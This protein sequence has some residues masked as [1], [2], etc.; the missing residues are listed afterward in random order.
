MNDSHCHLNDE[1]LLPAYSS[2]IEEAKEAGVNKI[3]CVGWDLE[4]SLTAI[5][6]AN[7]KPNVF[8]AIGFH[9]E[10]L[11]GISNEKL[12]QIKEL[13][14]SKKVVA[15]GEIGLDFHWFSEKDERAKQEE[16]FI[17]QIDLANALN[18]PVSIHARDAAEATFNVIESHPIK[19]GASLHCYSGSTEMMERFL[20]LGQKIY[21]GFDGPVTYKNS[22]TPK[23]NAKRCPINRLLVETDSPYLPPVPYRGKT[24]YPKYI[25]FIVEEIANLRNLTKEEIESATDKNFMNLFRIEAFNEH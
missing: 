21:F 4:S 24:N 25:P 1:R 18:L 23:E 15:I 2:I 12:E 11:N 17:K 6:I 22:V 10:N 7:S 20:S 8:A 5:K 16:W 3:L 9:P 19:A 14:N 13:C